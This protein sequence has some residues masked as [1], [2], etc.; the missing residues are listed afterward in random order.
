MVAGAR[1]L[2]RRLAGA[3]LRKL[4]R[5]TTNS[6]VSASNRLRWHG[7]RLRMQVYEAL[8]PRGTLPPGSL[9]ASSSRD[10][11]LDDKFYLKQFQRH[12]RIFKLFWGSG[13]LK[14]CLVGFDY[15]RGLLQQHHARL[16]PVTIDLTPLVP[17]EYLR[18]MRPEI[19]PQYRGAFSKGL[20]KDLVTELEPE[21]RQFVR[22]ELDGLAALQEPASLARGLHEVLDHVCIKILVRFVL[23]VR[24]DSGWFPSLCRTYRRL[25][26]G[27]Y[28]APIGPEQKAAYPIIRDLVGK[29]VQAHR[30]D[31]NQGVGDSLIGRMIH[32]PDSSVDETVIGNA[33]YMVER[34]RHDLRDLLWWC[35]RHLSDHPAV[36]TE[37]READA[38]RGTNSRLAEA[39]VLETLR[40]E[41]AE[42]LVRKALAPLTLDGYR[43]PKGSW[44][45]IL[46]RESHRDANVFPDPDAYRPQ[47]FLDRVY[48]ANEYAPFGLDEHHCIG[49]ALVVTIGTL[50]VQELVAGYE[51]SIAGDGPRVFGPL[52]WQ[53]SP[54]F[55]IDLRPRV[56]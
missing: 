10:A 38:A 28:V 46:M 21:F 25:G 5:W 55:A 33:I 32:A 12:G 27:D 4:T 9:A 14:I 19:H 22:D 13:H 1:T 18:S 15:A 44:V 35:T 2:V 40:L 20:R 39:C 47:R 11:H 3:D 49:R 24:P 29:I 26:P 34:G 16:H 45:C 7:A 6:V 42:V 52:H 50:F 31:G 17:N 41:Q 54:S 8:A 23:G 51:W 48:S 43:I 37:L 53:P 56:R 36:V 30:E